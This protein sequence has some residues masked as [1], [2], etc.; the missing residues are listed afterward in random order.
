[1]MKNKKIR[2]NMCYKI[3]NNEDE[4]ATLNDENGEFKGCPNC[5]TDAYL[6]EDFIK[7]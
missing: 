5:K 3:F 1:M 4:L 2:C 7:E 6:M